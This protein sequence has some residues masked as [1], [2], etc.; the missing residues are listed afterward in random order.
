MR[1]HLRCLLSFAFL[2]FVSHAAQAQEVTTKEFVSV[3]GRFGVMLP[4]KY[5]DYKGDQVFSVGGQVFRGA[6]YRWQ[7]D[8]DTVLISYG[9]THVDLETPDKVKEFL[10]S[11][12][13]DYLKKA[14]N[15]T[16]IGEKT[17]NLEG[18]PGLIFVVDTNSG[19]VMVWTYVKRNW[20][21]LNSLTLDDSALM[22]QHVQT[23]STFRFIPLNEI[24]ATYKPFTDPLTPPA[25]SQEASGRRPRTDAQDFGLI[26][27]VKQVVTEVADYKDNTLEDDPQL[28]LIETYDARG[29]LLRTVEFVNELPRV[30]RLYGYRDGERMLREMRKLPVLTSEAKNAA[31]YTPPP[32]TPKDFRLVHKYD[33]TGQLLEFRILG[34]KKD[35]ES[36][37]YNRKEKK[38]EHI[39][40]TAYSTFGGLFNLLANKVVSTLDD[41]GNPVENINFVY[42]GANYSD[43][44][45]G[46]VRYTNTTPKYKEVRTRNEY[47]YDR[48][49]NW[50][51]RITFDIG[52]NG[53]LTP[54]YITY[55]TI[56][57]Y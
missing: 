29:D 13:E 38:V 17:T 12:K 24:E 8:S 46:G 33:S 27:N 45:V 5:S 54:R 41:K 23:L 32:P 7:L 21:Y 18:H 57:Y 19:R 40:D 50:I 53:E 48:Q 42:D 47:Q 55:R 10:Q 30:V 49:G 9:R 25:P 26:D 44:F 20:L 34:E 31:V 51:K 28:L 2:I 43:T 1:S 37:V 35:L 6:A 14:A 3:M 11:V 36:F 22:Q 39:L 56:F 4:P 52:K 15:G 16:V